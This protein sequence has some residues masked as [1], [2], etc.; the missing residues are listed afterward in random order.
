M[1]VVFWPT[2]ATTNNLTQTNNHIHGSIPGTG[3]WRPELAGGPENARARRG[4]DDS[5]FGTG[6]TQ[7]SDDDTHPRNDIDGDG[8]VGSDDDEPIERNEE[9]DRLSE[10]TT[11][12]HKRR[13]KKERK[14]RKSALQIASLNLNGFGNLIRDHAEN[15]WGRLYR[16]MAE[17]RVGVLCL[18][19]T[20]LTTE[21]VAGIHKMFAR[22]IKILH[23]E[24]PE[25]PTQREGVAVVLNAKYVSTSDVKAREIVPGRA[26]QVSITCQGG[27]VRHLLCIYAPTSSGAAERSLFY[28]EVMKFYDDH[29]ECPKPHLMA[30][31]F[32][33]VEDTLDRLPMSSGRDQS[34][35][36]LDE[37]KIGLGLMLADGWRVT[38][39]NKR[40]YTFHR[41][42][43][44]D[45]TFSRLDRIYTTPE[46]FGKAREWTICEA[47]VKTDHSLV[48]VQLTAAN[49][50][51]VGEGRPLFPIRL[52][53][54]RKLETRQ[55][56]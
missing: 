9:A 15:K 3:T 20:H 4:T 29:P 53:K 38:N 37:L 56:R 27:D 19:E 39:P 54:D 25:A 26:I 40:A 6:S 21:R 2:K 34:V 5:H 13:R 42:T 10:K 32:N 41:G 12:S 36:A 23:S 8:N 49:A 16:V 1:I 50:P 35:T 30:G 14:D 47:G 55:R 7:G 48:K 17:H 46:I 31:D 28:G 11:D 24:N 52:I 22:R 43:G 18:Q 44:S 51:I 45:A 33:N